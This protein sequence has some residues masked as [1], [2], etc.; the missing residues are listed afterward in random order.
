M[1]KLIICSDGTWDEP[2][3]AVTNVVK[4]AR[5]LRPATAGRPGL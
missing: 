1:K 2:T 3:G 5:A 4:L